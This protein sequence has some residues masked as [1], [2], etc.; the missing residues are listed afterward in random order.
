MTKL[1]EIY[2]AEESLLFHS[3]IGHAIA[4]W[5]HVEYGLA[6]L[7]GV[8]LESINASSALF[9][10]ENFRS[11]TAFTRQALSTCAKARPY[12]AE[13]SGV[14]THIDALSSDRNQIAHSRTMVFTAAPAGRQYAV[15][16]LFGRQS[17]RT[18]S[19]LP[20]S[21]SKCVTDLNLIRQQFATAAIHLE[22]LASRINGEEDIFA[23][24]VR[25]VPQRPTVAQLRRQMREGLPPR[26]GSSR[27]Q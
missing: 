19:K 9:A 22:S 2:P 12:A 14:L 17:K 24:A 26:E 7:A 11:K 1:P 18:S 23:E 10:I 16:P 4:Q 8:C 25:R 3:L 5:A 27:G 15:L 6:L 21:G 13:A 20:P